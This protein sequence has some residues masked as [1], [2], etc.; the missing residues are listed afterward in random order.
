MRVKVIDNIWF[1]PKGK[2]FE[3]SIANCLKLE[4][5]SVL[6]EKAINSLIAEGYMEELK[7]ISLKDKIINSILY[8]GGVFNDNY[9]VSRFIKIAHEHYIEN[10]KEIN[11]LN[12]T[13]VMEI[14]WNYSSRAKQLYPTFELRLINN[15]IKDIE[16]L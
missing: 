15:L 7:N 2:I 16:K 11:C 6:T 12:K 8:S 1:A 14:L 3:L 13:E 10:P 9:I 5:G 4:D